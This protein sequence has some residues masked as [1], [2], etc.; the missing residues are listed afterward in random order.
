MVSFS[1]IRAEIAATAV[2]ERRYI[3]LCEKYGA[4]R[5]S[6]IVANLLDHSESMMRRDLAQYPNGTYKAVGFMDGD[7]L[8]EVGVK[9][10]NR[11]FL[12]TNNISGWQGND[13]SFMTGLA[14]DIHTLG[15]TVTVAAVRG[16]DVVAIGQ[17][18]ANANRHGFFTRIQV[19]EAGHEA[20][21]KILAS[22]VLEHPN[23]D[24][25]LVHGKQGIAVEICH[26][27]GYWRCHF[28]LLF[29]R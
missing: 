7:G 5:L 20:Q 24:H 19:N 17:L 13:L 14:G 11:W 8:S 25:A 6:H 21:G 28:L 26:G 9:R 15:N 4:D 27:L 22:E 10:G 2:G 23:L 18:G 16:G 1:D 29:R 3:E 12:D